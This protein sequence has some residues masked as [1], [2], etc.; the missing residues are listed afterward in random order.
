VVVIRRIHPPHRHEEKDM[1]SIEEL[2]VSFSSHRFSETYDHLSPSVRWVS[3]G[4]ATIVGRKAVV[5]ACDQATAE[6]AE[7][8]LDRR[9]F[10]TIV[11]DQGV[12]VDTVTAYVDP[13]GEESVV[14]SCDIY[15]FEADRISAITSYAV[16]V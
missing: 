11:G 7:L 6:M 8:R 16:E 9:R 13:S 1:A 3:V 5:E 15:E 2:A 12:A 14:A 4:S 10:L